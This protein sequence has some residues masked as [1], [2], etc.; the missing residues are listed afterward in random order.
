MND[1]N[2]PGWI[3]VK[4]DEYEKDTAELS[5]LR[6]HVAWLQQEDE[7]RSEQMRWMMAELEELRNGKQSQ[8]S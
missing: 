2:T 6:R 4:R 8:L 7:R 1:P 5:V 3:T